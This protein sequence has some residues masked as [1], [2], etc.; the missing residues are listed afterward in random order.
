MNFGS[1]ICLEGHLVL[2]Y[3]LYQI[4]NKVPIKMF[5]CLFFIFYIK[6]P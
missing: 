4:L 1:L 5:V 2:V 6:I 3:A